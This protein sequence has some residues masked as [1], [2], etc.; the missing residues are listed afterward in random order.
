MN[1]LAIFLGSLGVYLLVK[2]LRGE[3]LVVLTN[4]FIGKMMYDTSLLLVYT[5][6]YLVCTVVTV[7]ATFIVYTM[8]SMI[9]QFGT[10][11]AVAAIIAAAAQ[12]LYITVMSKSKNSGSGV[13]R[14]VMFMVCNLNYYLK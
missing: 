2:M 9:L 4:E 14:L 1:A 5:A 7:V 6:N 3:I 10:N 13:Y 8:Y 11:V 12:Q